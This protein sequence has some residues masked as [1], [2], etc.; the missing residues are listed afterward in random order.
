MKNIYDIAKKIN[1]HEDYV[2][3]Y[4]DVLCALLKDRVI[5]I[6]RVKNMLTKINNGE[7]IDINIIKSI[8]GV[9]W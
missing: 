3:P 9:Y 4:D 8:L 1:I 5:H 6:D 2:I 7:S